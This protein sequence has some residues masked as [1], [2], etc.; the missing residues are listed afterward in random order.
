MTY[1]HSQSYALSIF[2]S[3]RDLCS[4]AP[5]YTRN[6]IYILF[7]LVLIENNKK[8]NAIPYVLS[9]SR[10]VSVDFRKEAGEPSEY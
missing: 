1:I 10:W 2:N 3:N 9:V 4:L 6:Y 5:A 7:T 8:R